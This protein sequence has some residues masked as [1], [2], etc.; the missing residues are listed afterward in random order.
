MLDGIEYDVDQIEKIFD[1]FA[2][3]GI[4]IQS[5]VDPELE[6]IMEAYQTFQTKKDGCIKIAIAK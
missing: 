3:M 1:I 4:K 5:D 2:G 6:N